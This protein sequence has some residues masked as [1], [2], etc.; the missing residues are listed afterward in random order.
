ME[1]IKQLITKQMKTK[2]FFKKIKLSFAKKELQKK[3]KELT[4]W[5]INF[6]QIKFWHSWAT[7]SI[8]H[9]LKFS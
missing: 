6:I 8:T 4:I 3:L 1:T 5:M 9:K 7:L 2:S